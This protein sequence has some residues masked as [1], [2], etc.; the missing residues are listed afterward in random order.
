MWW[1]KQWDLGLK[2][3]RKS[4]KTHTPSGHCLSVGGQ[5]EKEASGDGDLKWSVGPGEWESGGGGVC[6]REECRVLGN[7]IIAQEVPICK[8]N[9]SLPHMVLVSS[10]SSPGWPPRHHHNRRRRRHPVDL[11][12]GPS[13]VSQCL[14]LVYSRRPV[15]SSPS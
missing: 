3:P 12:Q 15:L 7:V 14:A 1:T 9:I 13:S 6:S 4:I 11:A 8:L 10:S 2:L 5:E